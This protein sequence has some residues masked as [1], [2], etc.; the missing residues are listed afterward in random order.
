[1]IVDT[2]I[3]W[4]LMRDSM[5]L[6]PV[7]NFSDMHGMAG[8]GLISWRCTLKRLDA[9]LPCSSHLLHEVSFTAVRMRMRKD[10]IVS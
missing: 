10:R 6:H 4:V 7:R 5:S 2:A 8:L 1:M 9:L 3:L